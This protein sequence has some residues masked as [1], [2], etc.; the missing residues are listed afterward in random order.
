VVTSGVCAPANSSVATVTVNTAPSITGA[1]NNAVVCAGSTARFSV[2]ATGAGLTYQWQVS[3]NGGTTY[4]NVSTGSGGTTARYTTPVN[5]AGD[6]N[7][8]YRCVGSGTCSPAATSS[9]ATLTVGSQLV[10]TTQPVST[11]AGAT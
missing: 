3:I 1:P 6:N 2:T 11:T 5:V 7:N 4:N 10:F 8:K 9:A